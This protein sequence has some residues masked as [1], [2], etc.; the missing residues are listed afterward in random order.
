MNWIIRC[1]NHIAFLGSTRDGNVILNEGE[2]G[3]SLV[4]YANEATFFTQYGLNSRK[5][6]PLVSDYLGLTSC[7]VAYRRLRSTV[8]DLFE[9]FFTEKM[10]AVEQAFIKPF[11]F[12]IRI[13]LHDF[14]NVFTQN[15]TFLV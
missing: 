8:F 9:F 2:H 15:T 11:Y 10:V 6:P 5:R 7:V 13:L 4:S 14:Q 3:V 12:L 1:C